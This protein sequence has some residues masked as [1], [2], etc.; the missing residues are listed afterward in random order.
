MHLC[1]D[2]AYFFR[3]RGSTFVLIITFLIYKFDVCSEFVILIVMVTMY[4][5]QLNVEV[6]IIAMAIGLTMTIKY[7]NGFGY[8]GIINVKVT[9]WV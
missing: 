9:V 5:I 8:T 3:T 7:C 2:L 6:H 4:W 1:K